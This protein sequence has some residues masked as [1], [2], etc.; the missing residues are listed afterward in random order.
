[1][2]IG[3]AKLLLIKP[4][5]LLL[6]EPTN[7]LDL[8]AR[9]WLEQYLK[10]YPYAFVLVSHDRYFLDVTVDR[11]LEIWNKPRLFLHRQLRQISHAKSRAPRP[12]RSR[13]PKPAGPHR[14]ARSLHQPLPLPGHQGQAGA[15]PHQGARQDRTHRN[16]GGREDHPLLFPAAAGRAGAWWR[17]FKS[18]A[19]SY[20]EK[21]V[22]ADVNFIV[23]RGDRIALV[24]VNGA[25][26]STLI[27]LLAGAETADRRRI[28]PGPQRAS[29]LLRA[30]PIQGAR[31]HRAAARRS[32]QRRAHG[33]Q[34][35][36]A[37]A[38]ACS[39][40]SC[41]PTTTSS[42][43]SACSPAANATATRWR[44]CC[45]S[46]RISCCSTSP[47]TTWICTPRTCCWR[48]CSKYT[49]TVVFVSHDRYFIDKLATRVF[50]IEDGEL[51]RLSRQLR[52][53]SVAARPAGGE[54][55]AVVAAWQRRKRSAAGG[56]GNGAGVKK[57][58]PA[59]KKVN[60]A[61]IRKMEE[62]C[63]H[64]EEEV[65]RVEAEIATY[66]QELAAFK[67]AQESIRLA[68]LI[69]ERRARLGRSRRSGRRPPLRW[70]CSGR[71]GEERKRD[72]L[73]KQPQVSG[74][75]G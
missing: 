65:A 41:S 53:L 30:G 42:S 60:P 38:L 13:L 31:S 35:P 11:I 22:F 51:Q 64:L 44:A 45:C 8:E 6:D 61:L 70:S 37:P 67:S 34:R 32:H 46:R 10:D 55:V 1:M 36:D 74:R 56:H 75:D 21:H 20:G 66:E 39:A 25:G 28:S 33:P 52:R 15:E 59:A 2:R 63:G 26:K 69:E 73:R 43:A 14:A 72:G 19:K 54:P 9:N 16:S 12:A 18:V 68:A 3:L 29:G 27:K 7:H 40:V 57:E 4:N 24:G 17:N 23:N 71:A 50:E 48:R 49:G 58:E 5:L 62:R 47:P